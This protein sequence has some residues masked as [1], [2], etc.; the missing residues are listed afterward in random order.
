MVAAVLALMPPVTDFV[1]GPGI[2]VPYKIEADVVVVAMEA[3]TR[4]RT[5]P[6]ARGTARRRE[7]FGV[8]ETGSA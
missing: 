6:H 8:L 3:W 1:S 4:R 7:D 2:T 5:N